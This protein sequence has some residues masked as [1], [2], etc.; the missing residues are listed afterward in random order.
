MS[1]RQASREVLGRRNARTG[2]RLF[3][4]GEHSVRLTLAIRAALVLL[5]YGIVIVAFWIGREGL[6][7][8]YDGQISF[9][10]VIY[11]SMVTVTT[12]GYGDIVPVS[13]T[14]RL[15][16]AF[17]V[18]PIRV[19]VWLIFIGTAYQLLIQRLLEE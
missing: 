15:I 6:R 19:F 14:A 13:A 2:K 18:T 8:N 4:G 5:M 3:V 9:T 10:D 11:F 1:E 17:F 7:D 12:V 16:D